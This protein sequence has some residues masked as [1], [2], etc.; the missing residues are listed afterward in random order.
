MLIAPT[1]KTIYDSDSNF[2][3]DNNNN[4]VKAEM[5]TKDILEH[6]EE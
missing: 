1:P 2:E 3:S 6:E 5:I 4:V